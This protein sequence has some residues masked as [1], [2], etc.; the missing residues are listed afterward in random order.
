[1]LVSSRVLII[2]AIYCFDP[3]EQVCSR[4]NVHEASRDVL[5]RAADSVE[6]L[7]ETN[8]LEFQNLRQRIGEV[9]DEKQKKIN[10]IV[11]QQNKRISEIGKSLNEVLQILRDMSLKSS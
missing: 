4:G 8:Q 5:E 7:K 2:I 11:S 6:K 10:E 3:I 1:M 9:S